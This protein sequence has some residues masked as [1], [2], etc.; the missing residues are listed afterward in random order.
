MSRDDPLNKDNTFKNPETVY[1]NMDQY[2]FNELHDLDITAPR[3]D[4]NKM[5]ELEDCVDRIS[6]IGIV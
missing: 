4:M 5:S 2:V 3:I 1:D 6:Q